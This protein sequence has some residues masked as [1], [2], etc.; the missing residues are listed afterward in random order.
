[1]RD[2]VPSGARTI[3]RGLQNEGFAAYVVGGC[4]RDSLL[5]LEPKDWDICTSAKPE[6]MKEYFTRCSVRTIDTGL[7]HGTITVDLERAGKFEVTTFRV[8]G[9]YSDN[10]HP[11][12]VEFVEDIVQDLSRRDFTINAMAYNAS[13]IVDPF[14]GQEDLKN[15]LIRCVGNPDDRFGEDALR[16]LRAMRFA[17]IYDFS[18]EDATA[19]SIHKNKDKLRNIAAERIQAEL[20]KMLCGKGVLNILLEYSDVVA[21]IIPELEPCIGFDQNNRFHEYTIYDH[22]AHSVANY[23]AT[24][25]VVNMALLLHDIGKPCCYTEDEK[26]GHFYGHGVY[27]RDLAENALNRLRFDNK[28]KNDILELVLFH[29]ALIEPTPKTVRRWLNKVGEK[30][31]GRLLDIRMA[32]IL[33]HRRDTQESRIERC[34]ALGAIASEIIEQN[35]C[36]KLR[37]LAVDGRDIMYF[38]N[39]KEGK[40]VGA[41]LNEL[42]DLV[43]NGSLENERVALIK[44]MVDKAFNREEVPHEQDAM[45]C[46]Q[47]RH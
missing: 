16:I 34:H 40:E 10:R 46:V 11:D 32:D 28:S 31:F 21:T 29:D 13:V 23:E 4:V 19:K 12:S 15:G 30:Q 39:L 38:F 2:L 42:L 41:V 35:Q 1:M 7:Q 36:F 47:R 25:T 24:D 3:I 22:I 14:H 44:Y 5:G 37:N 33:A 17:S 9:N 6:E 45:E 43:I 26:G 18:I 20:C 27:S 8:D